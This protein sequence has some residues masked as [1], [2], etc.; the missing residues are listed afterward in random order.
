M[1]EFILQILV[2][3]YARG[4]P[5]CKIKPCNTPFILPIL[6]PTP[7][8]KYMLASME[9]Y[10][11]S[12][13]RTLTHL[14]GADLTFT[15]MT[16]VQG[17]L[18]KSKDSL[19][20]ISVKDSTPVQIQ[21]LSS[22]VKKLDS[23]LS[24]FQESEGFRGFNLNLSCPSREVIKHGKGAAMVKRA[25]KTQRLV[26]LIRDYG[27][28]VSIKIS[29]GLNQF[30]KDNKL[31]L[32]SLRGVD[33]DFFIIHAK[34]AGQSSAES[35]DYSIFPEC[36]QEA[37]GIP[38]I[39]NGGINSSDKVRMLQSQG[40]KGVM[41]GRAAL[42]NPLIFDR[43]KNEMGVNSLPKKVLGF[44]ALKIEYKRLHEIHGSDDRYF[45]NFHRALGKNAV[46]CYK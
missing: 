24:G 1:P 30:E 17:I 34:H 33:P 25:K 39:A 21:I 38:V 9:G 4:Y 15:E 6:I 40:V 42:N 20:R 31:Y 19:K 14:H 22:S 3:V 26:E 23:L 28:P 12:V 27:F 10:T 16:H 44:D 35:E 36:V 32:N 37:R 29:L 8:F 43:I 2:T 45:V 13:F 11:N 18:R 41:I 5:I 7:L 46:S